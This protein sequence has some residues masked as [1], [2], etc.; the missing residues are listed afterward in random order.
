MEF[1]ISPRE[2]EVLELISKGYNYKEIVE[3]LFI[4]KETVISNFNKYYTYVKLL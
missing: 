1:N 3:T 4:S 2:K